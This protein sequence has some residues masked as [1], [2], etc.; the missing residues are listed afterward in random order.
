[1]T[2]TITIKTQQYVISGRAAAIIFWFTEHAREVNAKGKGEYAI[3][4]G[5]NSVKIITRDIEE[6]KVE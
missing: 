5:G 6:L 1:V 3:P 4:F 2:I